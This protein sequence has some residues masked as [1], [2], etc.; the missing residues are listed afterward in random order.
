MP[1]PTP[2]PLPADVVCVTEFLMPARDEGAGGGIVST[3]AYV[4]VDACGN[5]PVDAC[6][7]W[8]VGASGNS[9]FGE[10]GCEGCAEVAEIC[11]AFSV[12]TFGAGRRLGPDLLEGLWGATVLPQS[13]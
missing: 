7:N 3:P 1:L 13:G 10:E 12:I 8:P 6:G 2:L 5:W 4:P 11:M 9:F